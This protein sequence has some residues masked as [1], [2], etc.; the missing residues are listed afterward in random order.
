MELD[1]L[2]AR[3]QEQDRKL[4][5]CVRLNQ[6]LLRESL[7]E[8][9]DSAVA[10]LSRLLWLELLLNVVAA[11]LVGSFIGDHFQE[12]QFLVPAI[13][14]QLGIIALIIGAVRQL[15]AIARIDYAAPIVTIQE[16]LESLRAER[17]RTVRWTLILSPLAWTPLFIVA[18]K[19]LFDFDVYSAFG[20]AW[21]IA[22]LLFGLLV[23]VAALWVSRSYG[24]RLGRSPLI[25]R[26]LRDIGGQNLA[27]ANG[28]VQSVSR[29]AEGSPD[30]RG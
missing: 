30:E 18:V 9:A 28:F 19:G 21:L 5:D 8:K 22:N 4:D 17:I 20:P 1:E 14:L 6:Q 27:A 11:I 26:L 15:T 25:Q 13:A 23:I 24:D 12:P 16:R 3:W 2:K 10:R 7:L 29:F